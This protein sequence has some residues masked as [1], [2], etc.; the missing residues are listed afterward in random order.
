MKV[1]FTFGGLPHY[2]N[3]ILN[4][5]NRIE[6]LNIVVV[7]P[8]NKSKILGKNV[9]QKTD[10]IEFKLVQLEEHKTYYG[11]LFLK[12]FSQILKEEKPDVVVTI[13]PYILAFIFKPSLYFL[14]KRHKIKL[15]LK[16]IPF[17]VPKMKD[18]I[19]YYSIKYFVNENLEIQASS[20]KFINIFLYS[21]LT[22]LRFIYYHLCD[23]HLNY[24]E[25]AFEILGSYG[26]KKERIFVTYNS[27]DTD[28][29]F[30]VKEEV[31]KSE[32]LLP[33][34]KFRIM[35]VGRLV[36]WKRVD[37]LLE[38]TALLKNKIPGIELIVIGDGPQLNDLKKLS[39]SLNIEDKIKFAGSI[40][41]PVLLG[42]YFKASTIY[43]L[44][45]IGGLSI[46]EAMCFDKP[47][48]CSVCDG[49]EKKLV[50]EDY[51]GLYFKEGDVN[52]LCEK[53]L[54]LL[55]NPGLI[56]EMG[57]NSSKI[58]REE[59]NIHIVMEGY[60]RAFNYV[61]ENKFNLK[62]NRDK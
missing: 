1:L 54:Y 2:Y 9:H 35:H 57:R 6:G 52:D 18:A 43:I 44:A 62:Y 49:T 32:P 59:V 31:D 38:A 33:E 27:P 17:G 39:G 22:I 53:I 25:D 21:F 29:L 28:V 24:V 40:Y 50:R 47:V 30:K 15:L 58:I 34:N 5:L 11:K 13:W 10:D 16:E 45:G 46:N 42:R 37:L 14:I 19:K 36:E 3:S 20:N 48:I 23:A 7:Y 41:D 56:E 51:N 61:S 55:S 8:K 26:V 60:I 4:R 12:G